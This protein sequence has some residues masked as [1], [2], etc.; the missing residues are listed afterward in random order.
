MLD[1][2]VIDKYHVGLCA[3]CGRIPAKMTAAYRQD[4]EAGLSKGKQE[5]SY[6]SGGEN[7]ALKLQHTASP[8]LQRMS[9]LP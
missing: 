3:T 7:C 6:Y 2:L 4:V 5:L 8:I 9:V 1:R